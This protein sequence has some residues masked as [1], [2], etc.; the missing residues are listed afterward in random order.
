MNYESILIEPVLSEKSNMMRESGQ[1]VFKVDPR[2]D[3]IMIM[4]AVRRMFKVNP[5]GCRVINV[6]SKPKK[7]RGRPGNTAEWKKAIVKLQKGETIRVFE[8]A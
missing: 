5:V 1:Y 6:A 3:K 4:E 2:A 7:L 8:G